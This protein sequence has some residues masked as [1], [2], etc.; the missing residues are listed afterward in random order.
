MVGWPGGLTRAATTPS[1][2]FPR[3][4]RRSHLPG[5]FCP[6]GRMTWPRPRY[7]ARESSPAQG[8]S[9]AISPPGLL[10]VRSF[11]C[12]QTFPHLLDHAL[13]H[14]HSQ[15]LLC[16]DPSLWPRR[17]RT[18]WNSSMLTGSIHI[19]PFFDTLVKSFFFRRS[20]TLQINGT[21]G[22][23]RKRLWAQSRR[24]TTAFSTDYPDVE[25]DF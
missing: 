4:R 25:V 19:H 2:L 17:G 8:R 3:R 22:F 15:T 7:R 16:T 21:D 9:Q 1:N 5:L 14:T 12:Y 18:D 13:T 24:Q 20:L 23:A 6:H 10:R 11:F